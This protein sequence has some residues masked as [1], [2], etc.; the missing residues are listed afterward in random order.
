MLL[1]DIG[2]MAATVT[3]RYSALLPE[4]VFCLFVC[5]VL[6]CFWFCFIVFLYSILKKF[7]GKPDNSLLLEK[8]VD[9]SMHLESLWI[10]VEVLGKQGPQE[11]EKSSSLENE[12]GNVPHNDNRE[13]TRLEGKVLPSPASRG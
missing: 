10:E 13:Q 12:T 11:G 3:G 1:K 2:K 5:F 8:I 9:L 7:N 4:R 6:I